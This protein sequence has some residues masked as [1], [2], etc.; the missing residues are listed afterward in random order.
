MLR[1]PAR[2][3]GRRDCVLEL[4]LPSRR[5]S[6]SA[7]LLSQAAADPAAF[8]VFY[9]QNAQQ[10]LV[11]FSRRVLDVAVA[12]DLMSETFAVALEQCGKF[13]G[14]T[15]EEERGWLYAIARTQLARFWRDGRVERSALGRLGVEAAQLADPEIE[16]VEQLAGIAELATRVNG[17]L[18]GLPPDQQAAIQ[19]RVI[20]ELDY[21]AVAARLGISEEA[22]RARV[23]RGLRTLATEIERTSTTEDIA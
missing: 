20:D 19:M 13:R 4:R 2:R 15:P 17:G 11:F 14:S 18:A 16:R 3:S 23:S 5:A 6:G 10:L 8:G 9:E 21:P 7:C 12:F 22:A 1:G